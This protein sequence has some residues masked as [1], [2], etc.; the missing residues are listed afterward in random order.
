MLSIS[1]ESDSPARKKAISNID[2]IYLIFQYSF[3][4]LIKLDNEKKNLSRKTKSGLSEQYRNLNMNWIEDTSK[5]L[6]AKKE[7]KKYS[8][9]CFFF[10]PFCTTNLDTLTTFLNHI[11]SSSLFFL[12][13]SQI[14]RNWI[15]DICD[16]A[17]RHYINEYLTRLEPFAPSAWNS[18]VIYYVIV[19]DIQF[20]SAFFNL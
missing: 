10:C 2:L 17:C 3:R 19:I 6:T 9:R 15:I 8:R 4:C 16:F 14:E 20:F 5:L 11:Q 7:E 13:F 1:N 12:L 18:F